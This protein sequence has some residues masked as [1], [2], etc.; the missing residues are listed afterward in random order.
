MVDSEVFMTLNMLMRLFEFVI[1]ANIMCY[2]LQIV[3]VKV[4]RFDPLKEDECIEGKYK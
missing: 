3:A 4:P 1:R 2:I